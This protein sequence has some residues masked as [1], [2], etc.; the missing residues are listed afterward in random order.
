[1]ARTR[2][3]D[4]QAQIEVDL[5]KKKLIR[6]GLLTNESTVN[7]ILSMEVEDIL[8]RRLQSV[9]YHKGLAGT[10]KQARQFVI[11]G[12]ISISDRVVTTPGQ[13]LTKKEEADVLFNQ[14]SPISNELHPARIQE[15]PVT[16]IDVESGAEGPDVKEA[17]KVDEA[18]AKAEKKEAP[19]K[20]GK[21]EAPAKAEKKEA[22]A[23][24]GKDEAPA[25][26]GKDEAPAKAEKD[27]APAK[28]EK[29]EAPAK[30]EKKETPAKEDK[31]SKAKADAPPAEKKE[32][33][34]KKPTKDDKGGE[35]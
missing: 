15:H 30:A 29:K 25:K 22:P 28:A 7:D 10:Q 13:A 35:K 24:A 31:P 5:L 12:H 33:S 16:P 21:E 19:A 11:H 34:E 4:M 23:K 17:P 2:V 14:Y 20:A 6:L 1:M 32:G 9:V 26:A 18:P 8:N 3:A 27:E